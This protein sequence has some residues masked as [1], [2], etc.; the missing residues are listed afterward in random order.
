MPMSGLDRTLACLVSFLLAPVVLS[1]S[2][3]LTLY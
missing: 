3:Q 2:F 1:G